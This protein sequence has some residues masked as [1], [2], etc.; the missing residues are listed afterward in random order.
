MMKFFDVTL[1]TPNM[2]FHGLSHLTRNVP[3]LLF[4]IRIVT[5]VP[6]IPNMIKEPIL[7]VAVGFF[8][9][10]CSNCQKCLRTNKEGPKQFAKCIFPFSYKKKVTQLN[11]TGLLEK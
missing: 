3:L 7:F 5:V 1:P 9:V 8:L 10:C 6:L 11:F 2:N 4:L